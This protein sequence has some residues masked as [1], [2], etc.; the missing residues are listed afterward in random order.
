MMKGKLIKQ[1]TIEINKNV[2]SYNGA[3]INIK[4][5]SFMTIGR[6]PSCK[7]WIISLILM[8]GSSVSASMYDGDEK[9]L[10]IILFVISLL[11]LIG[12]IIYNIIRDYSLIVNL[13]SGSYMGFRC[14]DRVFLNS[15]L[16]KITEF[17]NGKYEEFNIN[18]KD[19][20]IFGD[21]LKQATINQSSRR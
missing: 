14:K 15:V 16:I 10:I 20:K 17:M 12:I 18:F 19:C 3:F 21:V 9:I 2:I 7:L 8:W 6:V 1:P 13:N 11:S 4:N 5:I